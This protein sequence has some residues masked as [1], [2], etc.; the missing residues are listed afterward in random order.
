MRIRPLVVKL[1]RWLALAAMVP[2]VLLGLT[3]AVLTFENELD[4]VLNRALWSVPA[5]R[6][7]LDWQGVVDRV[8]ARYPRD[9]VTAVRLPGHESQAAELALASGLL[10]Y[11]DPHD[12]A[13]M[14]ARRRSEIQMARIHQFHTNLLVGRYGSQVM[15]LAA[16]GL[17]VL[18]LSGLVLWWRGKIAAIR[19]RGSSRRLVYD[20]HSALGLYGL[21]FWVVLGATGATMTFEAFAEP[22]LYWLT[23]SERLETPTLRS[24]LTKGRPP[25]SVDQALAIAGGALPGAAT[26][27]VSLPRQ[28]TGVIVAYMKYPEDRTPAGRSRVQIDRYSGRVLWVTDTRRVPLATWLWNHN[29]SMHTGD[30]FGWPSRLSV[31]LASA[32]LALQTGTGTILW[33]RGWRVRTRRPE[34]PIVE[35]DRV[36]TARC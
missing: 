31:C 9:R 15:G 30:Q 7:R 29:R 34:Q 23:R 6:P 36:G 26:T 11:C 16:L 3:G 28:P 5:G 32:L 21:V 24:V 18:S 17:V 33:W 19:L 13:V 20:A 1:H 14:G 22:A 12:G 2:L 25:I 4:R 8:Q 27:L 10:V 35:R